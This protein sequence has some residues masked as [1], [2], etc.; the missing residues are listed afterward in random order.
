MQ[1]ENYTIKINESLKNVDR[2]ISKYEGYTG[3]DKI[4]IMI[5]DSASFTIN[6]GYIRGKQKI[7]DDIKSVN[8]KLLM[9]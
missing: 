1:K 7:V 6:D 4:K 9:T 2:L 3:I 8:K 5:S